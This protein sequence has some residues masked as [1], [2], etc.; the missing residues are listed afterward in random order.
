MNTKNQPMQG[1]EILVGVSG[2][3][4]AYKTADLTSK[5]VQQGAAVS[6]VMTQAAQKFIG[7][8]TFEALTGR[9]VYQ[10]GFSPREHF[11]GEHIGLVRR[12]E[13][14]VI[15]PATANVMAQMAHGF[16]EDL[17]STLTLTCTA[18]IL[19]APAMNA[20]MWAKASVQRNLKQLQA[21]GIQIVEPGEGWLSCGVIGKGRMAE[22]AEILTRINELLG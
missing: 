21:D 11:Q 10:D 2:G 14:F 6:V 17:L 19:L 18:P 22:P 7:A 13:L 8:T 5:L 20:D 3:I 9:P 4:A 12:A 16:A 1:R 15:A